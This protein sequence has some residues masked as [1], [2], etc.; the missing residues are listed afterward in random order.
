M[1]SV[2]LFKALDWSV[3]KVKKADGDK[4]DLGEKRRRQEC[5]E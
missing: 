5:G 4:C 2:S 1:V 3:G